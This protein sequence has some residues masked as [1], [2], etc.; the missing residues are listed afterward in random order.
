MSIVAAVLL[1]A[2]GSDPASDGAPPPGPPPALVDPVPLDALALGAADRQ[3]VEEFASTVPASIPD[4]ARPTLMFLK[5]QSAGEPILQLT[6]GTATA[7]LVVVSLAMTTVRGSLLCFVGDDHRPCSTSRLEGPVDLPPST[8]A[9]VD[10][11]LSVDGGEPV[12]FLYLVAGDDTRPEPASLSVQAWAGHVADVAP[13]VALEES[14]EVLGGCDFAVIV[15]STERQESFKPLVAANR[16][17]SLWLVVERCKGGPET[18]FLVAI[19][20]RTQHLRAEFAPWHGPVQLRGKT[21]TVRLPSS[22]LERDGELQVAVIR[23]DG[24]GPVAWF[25][26]AMDVDL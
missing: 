20:D 16:S 17:Q 19:A 12:T 11:E 9:E 25:T 13:A 1:C 2:C 5:D 4:R 14:T 24:E 6:D 26:H 8:G 3:A 18:V 10:I 21:T 7:Q 22:F 15:E 23:T